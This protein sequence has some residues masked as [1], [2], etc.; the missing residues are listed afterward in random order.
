M[1]AIHRHYAKVDVALAL[2]P[3]GVTLPSRVHSVVL[4]RELQRPTM[5]ALALARATRPSTLVGLHVQTD[6]DEAKRLQAEWD[7]REIPSRSW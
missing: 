3:G 7:E 5:H 6:P 2:P 4:V 1:I